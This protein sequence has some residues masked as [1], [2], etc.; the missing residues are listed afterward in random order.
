MDIPN[1]FCVPVR[2]SEPTR[3]CPIESPSVAE[4]VSARG[5]PSGLPSF[6]SG[7]VTDVRALFF[8]S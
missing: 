7:V 8:F 3:A 1:F 4:M 6:W 2:R 5:S